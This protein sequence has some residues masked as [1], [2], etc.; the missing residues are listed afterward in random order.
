MAFAGKAGG[1][2]VLTKVVV[3]FGALIKFSNPTPAGAQTAP[4][5]RASKTPDQRSSNYTA[6]N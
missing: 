4:K 1:A 6:A 5:T 3:P 2:H